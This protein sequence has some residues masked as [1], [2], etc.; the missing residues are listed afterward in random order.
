MKIATPELNEFTAQQE[1]VNRIMIMVQA[2]AVA[3]DGNAALLAAH[4]AVLSVFNA[5]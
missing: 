1:I 2:M 5:D 4:E 3:N